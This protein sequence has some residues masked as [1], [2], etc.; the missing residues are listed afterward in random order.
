MKKNVRRHLDGANGKL[1]P[2]IAPIEDS[3]ASEQSLHT[4][5]ARPYIRTKRVAVI[6]AT[7]PGGKPWVKMSACEGGASVWI[8]FDDLSDAA[9]PAKLRMRAA[10][11]HLFTD[12]LGKAIDAARSVGFFPP[13]P[14]IE[15]PGWSGQHF[16]LRSGEVFSP[17]SEEEAVVLFKPDSATCTTKGSEKWLDEVKRLGRKQRLVTFS[18]MLPFAGPLLGLSRVRENIG[19]ELSGPKGVGKSTLQHLATSV[20]GPALEPAGKNYW[21]SANTTMNALEA[22]MG[23]H[24]DS[25]MIIEEMSVMHAGDSDKVRANRLREFIFR[26]AAGTAKGR[27]QEAK[28]PPSR[29]I[30]LTSTNEPLAVLLNKHGGGDAAEA[31]SDRLLAIPVAKKRK[32]GVFESP[33]PKGCQNGE[34]AARAI[35]NLA[36]EHYGLAFRQFLKQLVKQRAMDEGALKADIEALILTFREAVGVDG[37][38]GS[39]ARVADAFGLVYAAGVLAQRF[40]ALPKKLDCLAAA[41]KCHSINRK[42]RGVAVT[43]VERLHRLA[44]RK[45]VVSINL[46]DSSKTYRKLLAQAPALLQKSKSGKRELLLSNAQLERAFP[47]SKAL[48]SDPVVKALMR[49]DEGRST[50]NDVTP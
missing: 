14:L 43:N 27:Y 49:H 45:G 18:L 21:I 16:A 1:L 32:H 34:E 28:Q 13:L 8:P 41:S 46:K 2:A 25:I 36:A 5:P 4:R 3:A 30:W 19:F 38:V 40:G 15:L 48:L 33:L 6:G 50:I 31:A 22:E 11:L 7:D 44:K 39:D 20:V 23:G 9:A 12:S 10:G 42:S 17:N 37:N 35:D 26:M 29:F 24:S 47:N